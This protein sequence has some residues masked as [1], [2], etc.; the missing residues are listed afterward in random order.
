MPWRWS[1]S[2]LWLW[3]YQ[4]PVIVFME[5]SKWLFEG[6]F[7][8][9]EGKK[10]LPQPLDLIR[11]R[12]A[13]SQGKTRAEVFYTLWLAKLKSMNIQ[14]CWSSRYLRYVVCD[15]YNAYKLSFLAT[16]ICCNADSLQQLFLGQ[17]LLLPLPN[18]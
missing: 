16:T 8:I 14:I 5:T 13:H 7:F 18:L 1:W 2:Q 11:A 15:F 4:I 17:E 9:S 10:F 12:R 6:T 3:C